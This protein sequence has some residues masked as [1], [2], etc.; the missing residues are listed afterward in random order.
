MYVYHSAEEVPS[1]GGM[2]V[3]LTLGFFDGVHI[4]H[5]RILEKVGTYFDPGV[6]ITGLVTFDKHPYKIVAPDNAP[7]LLTL[8]PE[9]IE[10]LKSFK[11]SYILSM[12]FT[13][14]L[15]AMSA[16]QFTEEILEEKHDLLGEPVNQELNQEEINEQNNIRGFIE[17]VRSFFTG[18]RLYIRSLFDSY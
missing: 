6:Q 9:K 2:N 1:S 15:T 7:K 14:E 16:R 17:R 18:F 4:G 12:P 8:Q 11:L 10:I 3:T 13:Q 5:R